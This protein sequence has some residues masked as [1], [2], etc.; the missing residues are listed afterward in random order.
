MNDSYAE[1]APERRIT[2]NDGN[3]MPVIGLGTWG[4]DGEACYHTVLE[5]L[6]I[7]YR[8]ID[9]ASMYGN[10]GEI[11]RAVRDSGLGRSEVFI[12]TKVATSEQGHE[13]TLAACQASLERLQVSQIDLYLI[14]WPTVG[15]DRDTWRA[16]EELRSSGL[17]RSIGVS[18]FAIPR[19]EEI[20]RPGAAVPAV[21]QIEM[22]P[23]AYDRDV[24]RYCSE[25]GIR[26]EAYSPLTRGACLQ[27]K[28]L[29]QIASAYE[30]SPAQVLL[31]WALQKG[32][33][34]IPKASSTDHLR[35][36]LS[37]FDFELYFGDMAKLDALNTT[38]G[39]IDG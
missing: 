23:F 24:V 5:A 36:N 12:T 11:G 20:M 10:E 35:E 4:L 17:V 16:M 14:H 28:E 25:K 33:T 7:G 38:G 22:S 31:R 21:N 15:K 8:L 30:R 3:E 19:L 37:V 2:L 27:E 9:T 13:G 29:L 6:R 39:M 32:F 26:M 34:V 1:L 18:N